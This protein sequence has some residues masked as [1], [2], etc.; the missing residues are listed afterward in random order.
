MAFSLMRHASKEQ[1]SG[2]TG[3]AEFF[4]SNTQPTPGITIESLRS[5]NGIINPLSDP[6]LPCS[7]S[8]KGTVTIRPRKFI[9]NRLLERRQMVSPL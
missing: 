3:V 4:G 2:G 5:E 6:T 7:M 8:T 9:T 1:I